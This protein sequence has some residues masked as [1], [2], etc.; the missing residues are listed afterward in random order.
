L[1]LIEHHKGQIHLLLT[2]IVL[3]KMGGREI[4]HRVRTLRPGIKVPYTCGYTD[5]SIVENGVLESGVAFL[6]KP[7]AADE[8]ARKVREVLDAPA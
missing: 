1:R 7:F 2:D 6:Q 3:P 4:A 5:R 8:L